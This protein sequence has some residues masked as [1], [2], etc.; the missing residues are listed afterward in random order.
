MRIRFGEFEYDNRRLSRRGSAVGL[1]PKAALL[2]DALI[3]AAPA[4]VTK[5]ELYQRLW[6]G[7]VVEQGNLHN[8]I[9]ELRAAVG[10]ESIKT[11]HRTGYAFAA[12][13]TRESS[14]GPRLEI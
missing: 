6:R 11:V 14:A 10:Q 5:E 2:L 7:V 13:L 9:S 12:P 4:V 3:A 1:T 8:L